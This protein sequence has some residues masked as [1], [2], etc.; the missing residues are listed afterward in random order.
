MER[1]DNP[2]EVMTPTFVG[3]QLVY[4]PLLVFYLGPIAIKKYLEEQ[5]GTDNAT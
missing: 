5:N 4:V 2:N 3:E 1:S